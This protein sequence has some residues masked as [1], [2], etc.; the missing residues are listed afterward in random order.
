[1]KSHSHRN[2][3]GIWSLSA[4]TIDALSLPSMSQP[5]LTAYIDLLKLCQRYVPLLY[6][7]EYY[8]MGQSILGLMP[9]RT[10]N[11]YLT[12]YSCSL[13]HRS[14]CLAANIVFVPPPVTNS[15]KVTRI[16]VKA[17]LGKEKSCTVLTVIIILSG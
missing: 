10:F 15:S 12:I 2:G 5:M 8:A 1:M 16:T 4:D 17:R 7:A 3:G 11:R 9:R 6:P 13:Y 14:N